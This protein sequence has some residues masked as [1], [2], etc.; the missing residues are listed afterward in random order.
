MAGRRRR[1]PSALKTVACVA[2]ADNRLVTMSGRR[3][4]MGTEPHHGS[5]EPAGRDNQPHGLTAVTAQ[6]LL[7]HTENDGVLRRRDIKAVNIA[8]YGDGVRMVRELEGV[9]V[10]RLDPKDR[11]M[12][13]TSDTTGRALACAAAIRVRPQRQSG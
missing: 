2:P 13:C 6:E 1:E 11:Q 12:R 5:F 4:A 3:T 9:H 8:Y 7:I 10:A